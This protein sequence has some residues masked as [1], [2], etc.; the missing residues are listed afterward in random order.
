MCEAATF[1]DGGEEALPRADT[2]GFLVG[3][4]FDGSSIQILG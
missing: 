4:G 1:A 2:L 3:L